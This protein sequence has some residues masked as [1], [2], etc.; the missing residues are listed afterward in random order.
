MSEET[1]NDHMS[2]E[3]QKQFK[4]DL[5]KWI[6]KKDWLE[7]AEELEESNTPRKKGE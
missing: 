1:I 2:K 6:N 7:V 4:K 5:R 3:D